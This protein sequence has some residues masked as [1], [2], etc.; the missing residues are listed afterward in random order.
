MS[1]AVGLS[2]L[3]VP[4]TCIHGAG[5]YWKRRRK[6]N[7]RGKKKSQKRRAWMTLTAVA[8]LPGA[9]AMLICITSHVYV[10]QSTHGTG[11]LYRTCAVL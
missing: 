3:L 9:L 4:N 6:I 7:K 11:Y 10:Q 2:T 5:R 1:S 8:E